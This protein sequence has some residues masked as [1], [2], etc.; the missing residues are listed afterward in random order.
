M[1]SGRSLFMALIAPSLFAADFARLG[2]AL[3]NIKAAGASMVHVDVCDGHFAPGIT[4]GQ[5]VIKGLRRATDLVLDVHLLVERPER[6]AAEFVEAGA[7]W[8]S[9]H[10]E[11][12]T[13]LHRVLEMI[14]ACGAKAGAALN[15]STPV[16]A[17]TEAL[18]QLDF[19]TILAADP[20][21]EKETF[22]PAS[23]EK[24]RAA[25]RVR[26]ERRRSFAIQVEG[27]VTLDRAEDLIRAGADILVA[28]SDIFDNENPKARLADWIRLAATTRET[29]RV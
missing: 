3:E 9:V 16:E 4:A 5:P 19:L 1:G 15:P 23:L 21:L 18:G 6:Y 27:G 29:T 28:G 10:P 2:E 13:N 8:V 14:R 11:A 26:D 22:I 7:D 20:S 12:T 17:L 24:L 25:A